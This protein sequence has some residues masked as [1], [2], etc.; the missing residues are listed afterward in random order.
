MHS[1][2]WT[3]EQYRA[4]KQTFDQNFVVSKKETEIEREEFS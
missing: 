1:L 3:K 2:L 4:R